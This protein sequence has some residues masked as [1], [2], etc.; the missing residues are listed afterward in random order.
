MPKV[1]RHFNKKFYC[2][3]VFIVS[4][5]TIR[6]TRRPAHGRAGLVTPWKMSHLSSVIDLPRNSG[7]HQ[8][9]VVSI[10]SLIFAGQY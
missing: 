1:F 9:S 2:W 8:Q 7:S 10:I 5:K 4:N 3:F 6:L